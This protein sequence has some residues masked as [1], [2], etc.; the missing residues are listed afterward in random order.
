MDWLVV[1]K[2]VAGLGLLVFGAELLVR[3]AAR[4]AAAAGVSSLVIGLTVVAFGTSSPEMAVSVKAAWQGQADMAVG[5]VVGSNI[6][7]IM[8]VL[9]VS[10]A[11]SPG[12]L[13]VA[14]SMVRFDMPV[15]I[16]VAVA[17][18]PIFARGR[19]IPR[20]EGVVFL[21]YYVAYTV[22]LVLDAKR[23]DAT[24]GYA[25]AMLQFVI[26]LTVLTMGVLAFR[27]WRSKKNGVV[28]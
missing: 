1:V 13:P 5:N 20:W 14:S 19:M 8:G 7:N 12:G 24:A 16:A 18:L 25:A 9:G 26:P 28:Q 27:V 23:H 3:G 2:F 22:Y 21:L 10:G 17:C 15:M 11:V 4:L 6:F